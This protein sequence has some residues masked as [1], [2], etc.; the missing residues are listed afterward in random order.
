MAISR[1]RD[2]VVLEVNDA[3]CEI[4]GLDRSEIVG[5]PSTSLG[6]YADESD[7]DRIA[8]E[9]IANGTVANRLVRVRLP[10][11]DV[12]LCSFTISRIDV[13]GEPCFMVAAVDVSSQ[14]AA[15]DALRASEARFAAFF[16]H[17]GVMMIITRLADAHVVDVND[18]FLRQT[19]FTRAEVI[20]KTADDLHVIERPEDRDRFATALRRDGVI[21]DLEIPTRSKAGET[22]WLLVTASVTQLEG[23]PHAIIALVDTTERKRADEALRSSEGRYRNLVEQTADG[24]LLLDNDGL[25]VDINPALAALTGRPVAELRGTSWTDYLVAAD[26]DPVPLIRPPADA[27]EPMAFERR[28]RR[29]DGSIAE[30]E[31]HARYIADGLMLG[32]AR[33]IGARK[34]ADRERARLFRAIE[35]TGESIVITDP[36]GLVVYVNGAFEKEMGY[37]RDEVMGRR[38]S[39]LDA[40]GSRPDLYPHVKAETDA[41]G[42]WSGEV[43]I[44]AKDGSVRRDLVTT[45]AVRDQAGNLVNYVAVL[46]S[47][48]HEREL[49]D[50]LRQAQKME[51]VG[52]LAGGVAHDF[53]NLLTAISGFTELATGEAEPNSE[54]AGYLGEIRAS[55]ERA[56]V[57][58][59]QLLA[60]GRR[61]VLQQKVLDLN[62]VVADLAPMLRR[63]IGE[64][65]RLVV[66]ANLDLGRTLA[67]RGQLEQ[68]IVNLAVNARDAM[69]SGGQ[70][71]IATENVTLEDADVASH[72][73]IRPGAFVRL[74]I[75]DT[76]VG[77]DAGTTERIFEPFFTTKSPGS[78]T[79]LGL[80]TV[81]GIVR[82]SGG[83]VSVVSEPGVGSVF[84]IDLPAVDSEPDEADQP[85]LEN[86]TVAGRE[87]IL[88]VEDEAA[89]L[90]FAAQLLERNGYTVLRAAAGDEAIEIA[91]T[92]P[93]RID[94]LF[95]DVVMPGLTGQ[96]TAEAVGSMRPETRHLLASGYSDELNTQRGAAPLEVPFIEKPY[97][98]ASLLK[99]VR[100]A[101][102]A[103]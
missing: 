90:G 19:G 26:L 93:A 9:V 48:T 73:E 37:T 81:F 30:I 51:A 57:L 68:V 4:V 54:L 40:E 88:V 17:A 16:K 32:T 74:S 52:R 69:P 49:E 63:I 103:K 97:S 71:S 44:H 82:Q 96:E 50:Q 12:G 3:Y 33:D 85:V 38:H 92:Y 91:R 18:E 23:E 21:R 70:L 39:L 77:M 53:N 42:S 102:D 79:G 34:A 101:I 75:T 28:I 84:H 87:T 41:D 46:H 27:S 59:R 76:G 36:E 86:S 99:A 20:G 67:D 95:S 78:G 6:L 80:S 61:A 47:V 58:T 14:Q 22:R 8:A 5:K 65:I 13:A 89:V 31:I 1:V 2:G 25:I 15:Q 83:R 11:G 64:D 72:P 56:T 94:L 66:R 43:L 10:G 98:A 45:S 55:A 24:V 29:P 35:Q 62:R 7:R 100:Q 60:F